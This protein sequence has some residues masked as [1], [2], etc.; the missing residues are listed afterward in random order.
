MKKRIVCALFAASLMA[1][2]ALAGCSG[3]P[4]PVPVP[5]PASS[6]ASAA[7][8]ESSAAPAEQSSQQSEAPR[9]DAVIGKLSA[10]KVGSV[11]LNTDDV[12]YTGSGYIY[13]IAGKYGVVSLDGSKDTGAKYAAAKEA[14]GSYGSNKGF[15]AVRELSSDNKNINTTGLVDRNGNEVIPCKYAGIEMLNDRYAK[16]I[17]ADKE[18]KDKDAALIYFTDKMFSLSPDEGDTMYTGKWEVYDVTTKQLVKNVSGTHPYTVSAKG[19]FVIF[20]DD[21]A[22]SVTVDATGLATNEGK[23]IYDDGSYKLE[24]NGKGE[25]YD[26]DDQL[27]FTYDENAYE[28]SRYVEPYYVARTTDA[29][30]KHTYFLLDKKG[31]TVSKEFSE[32]LDYVT[33]AFVLSGKR[34]CKLDGT[35]LFPN[36]YSTLKVDKRYGDVYSASKSSSYTIFDKNGT[37]L[38]ANDSGEEGVSASAFYAYKKDGYGLH[39][40]NF[41]AKTFSID[42]SIKGDWYVSV[43]NGKVCDLVQTRT[44]EKIIDSSYGR[45]EVVEDQLEKT[46]YIIAMN[47]VND[48]YSKGDFDIYQVTYTE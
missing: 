27:L 32:E 2:A 36:D 40:Y 39:Y 37:V 35:Q 7:P 30:Y 44:G 23:K 9:G 10:R 1:T 26:T 43:D 4:V 20:K 16:V 22:N 47:S 48:K 29:N 21:S 46:E 12:E 17:T 34:V 19:Q 38:F 25:V 18:T 45:F 24:K 33:P 6:A 14:S 3:S 13:Q 28:V 11:K 42:G 5:A 15:I 8:A 31:N 41:G